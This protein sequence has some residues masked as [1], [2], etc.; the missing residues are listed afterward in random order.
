MT[1]I[2]VRLIIIYNLRKLFILR[3]SEFPLER[4]LI[5][6]NDRFFVFAGNKDTLPW[7]RYHDSATR[8]CWSR[9]EYAK[10]QIFNYSS[11]QRKLLTKCL[12]IFTDDISRYLNLFCN[13]NVLLNFF[14]WRSLPSVSS[15]FPGTVLLHH[16]PPKWQ[17]LKL[18]SVL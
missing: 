11:K 3:I 4:P 8:F 13:L 17:S 10:K 12:V 5:F 18:Q 1:G 6:E 16:E 14:W 9:P 2:V 15:D 7:N